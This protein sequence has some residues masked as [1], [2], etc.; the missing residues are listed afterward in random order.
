MKSFGNNVCICCTRY[1]KTAKR[2]QS[3]I[4]CSRN[5]YVSTPF[6][7]TAGSRTSAK[8]STWAVV[9]LS[10]TSDSGRK[11]HQTGFSRYSILRPPPISPGSLCTQQFCREIIV[12]KHL[13]H[14]NILPLLGVSLS[15]RPYSFRMVSP[16]MKNGNVMEYTR[17]NPSADRLKLV[18]T[19]TPQP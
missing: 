5:L 9:W 12:W 18:S 3:R 16:W 8:E 2:Y 4:F 6:T 17:S 13:S 11:T 1:A 14:P 19:L 10:K 15:M 7:D